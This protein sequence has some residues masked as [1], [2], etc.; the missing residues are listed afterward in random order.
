MCWNSKFYQMYSCKATVDD[1]SN[2]MGDLYLFELPPALAGVKIPIDA[3]KRDSNNGAPE[4]W[5]RLN[6]MMS[7][8]T[9]QKYA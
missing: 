3:D 7:R 5:M 2:Q 1:F 8:W 6:C 4:N 9:K